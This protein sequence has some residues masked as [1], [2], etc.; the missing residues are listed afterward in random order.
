MDGWMDGIFRVFEVR[1][2]SS[3]VAWSIDCI[4]VCFAGG[5]EWE[6]K[7]GLLGEGRRC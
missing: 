3:L 2:E 1:S 4:I 7:D 5:G 6:D